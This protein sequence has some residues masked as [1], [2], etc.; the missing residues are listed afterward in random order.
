MLARVC[1]IDPQNSEANIWLPAFV[2]IVWLHQAT[3]TCLIRIL[4]S[5]AW[6]EPRRRVLQ[7]SCRW[8]SKLQQLRQLKLGD[9]AVGELYFH[10]PRGN[11]DES[12]PA[13]RNDVRV[14][15]QASLRLRG[16]RCDGIITDGLEAFGERAVVVIDI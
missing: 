12:A 8:L 14:G 15:P 6:I 3:A 10:T 11:R 2:L 9:N 1:S 7:K 5:V 4:P 16:G 13:G